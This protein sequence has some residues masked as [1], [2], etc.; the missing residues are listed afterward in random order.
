MPDPTG[1]ADRVLG[2]RYRL[3]DTL[4]RGGMAD[5]FRADDLLLGR[6]VAV[7]LVRAA[8]G[9][10]T[11][12]RAR[13]E[14]TILAALNHPSLVTLY[15]AHLDADP[16][17]LVMEL[18][19]G[20]TLSTRLRDAPLGP[21]TAAT[22]AAELGEA[23][24]VAHSAGIVHRDVKPSNVLLA[25]SHLPDHEFRAKLADF[26]IAYL[27]D[28]ARVT[29]PG[30]VIGTAAYLA[31]EQVR[32]VEPAPPADVYALGL[33]LLESLTGRRA[34]PEAAGVATA[35]ARLD[36]APEIPESVD[37]RWRE[38]LRQMT[39]IA[40]EERPTA[41]DVAVRTRGWAAGPAAATAALA[42]APEPPSAPS[43]AVYRDAP[44][45]STAP[46]AVF[47]AGPALVAA[48]AAASTGS[49]AAGSPAAAAGGSAADAT[50]VMDAAS[51]PPAT[52]P[53]PSHGSTS[54]RSPGTSDDPP[55]S[56]RPSRRRRGVWIAAAAT[57]AIVA[58]SAGVLALTTGGDPAR[59]D[60]PA[61][62]TEPS[63]R[64]TDDAPAP[65]A[66]AETDDT[67]LVSTDDS[68][69]DDAP[70]E[71]DQPAEPD[72]Q[73]T[74]PG[75]DA[76]P[77]ADGSTDPGDPAEDTGDGD[78]ATPA[79]PVD[80]SPAPDPVETTAPEPPATPDAPAPS[81]APTG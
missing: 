77:P 24:H 46:T 78:P 50:Q 1:S 32:G 66:P 35:I 51:P 44:T 62:V 22:M 8:D 79:E 13:G 29:N 3:G 40:P 25:P 61:P 68:T 2:G 70:A 56:R 63:P 55:A 69:T 4:G 20:P 37:E 33:V 19:E 5:V 15:D 6:E 10:A 57:A 21:A 43:P 14:V 59:T 12:D 74:Q 45:P 71:P 30:E 58:G 23:L 65:D 17:F 76:P 39:A 60:D 31:P 72:E 48:S 11:D 18:V 28:T 27:V 42:V 73:P 53:I 16:A 26:G 81:P 36:H 7:K 38:L 52:A 80:P 67:D 75:D 54:T 47:A 41:L 9:V 34:F 64:A 49:D